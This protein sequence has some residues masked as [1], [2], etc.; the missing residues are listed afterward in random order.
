M[1]LS[2]MANHVD[3]CSGDHGVSKRPGS[4]PDRQSRA[5]VFQTH[6]LRLIEPSESCVT[7]A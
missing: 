3:F 6:S 7:S 2:A 4:L 1:A 5:A